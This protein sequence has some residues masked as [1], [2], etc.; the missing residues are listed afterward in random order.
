MVLVAGCLLLL[1]GVPALSCRVLVSLVGTPA[2]TLMCGL[3]VLLIPGWLPD[4]RDT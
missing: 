2:P 4:G 3:Q 1:G